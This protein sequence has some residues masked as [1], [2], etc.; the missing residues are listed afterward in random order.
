MPNG[1][2]KNWCR[3]CVTIDGFRSR[4]GRWP[5]HVRLP[6]ICI[7]DLRRLFSPEDFAKINRKVLLIADERLVFVAED[8]TGLRFAYGEE[9]PSAEVWL[10][11]DI[12]PEFRG[13]ID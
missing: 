8:D 4:H 3:L 11:V 5:S 7:G 9:P 2:D 6:Q 12:R 13:S 1:D 10:G